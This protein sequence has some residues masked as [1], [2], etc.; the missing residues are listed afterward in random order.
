[1]GAGGASCEAARAL[2]FFLKGKRLPCEVCSRRQ[3]SRKERDAP[4]PTG[5]SRARQNWCVRR[6]RRCKPEQGVPFWRRRRAQRRQAARS[7]VA[8]QCSPE[9]VG[10]VGPFQLDRESQ[11]EP[12]H[13]NTTSESSVASDS[14]TFP[15]RWTVSSERTE[16]T[17][18]WSG[19]C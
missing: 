4:N 10:S 7:C 17:N 16:V 2:F 18:R 19:S 11:I 13:Q 3:P 12:A 6:A 8:R 1:M 5:S 9:G 14:V 15:A